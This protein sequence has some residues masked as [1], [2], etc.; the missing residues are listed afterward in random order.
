MRSL[1]TIETTAAR[2][3]YTTNG[4]TTAF[5]TTFQ[6]NEDAD[7]VVTDVDADGVETTKTLTTHYTV[8]GG[9]TPAATGTVTMLVAPATGSL[10]IQRI[11]SQL[12]DLDLI[13]QG[14]TPADGLEAQLDRTTMIVQENADVADRSITLNKATVAPAGELPAPALMAS[15]VLAFDADG[16]PEPS[17]LTITELEEQ[18][19]NAAA[20]A[21]ASAS[22]ASAASTSASAAAS[23]ASAASSSASA[24]AASAAI[25][26]SP[27]ANAL[28]FIRVNAGATAYEVQTAAEVLTDI[29]AQPLDADL[30]ALAAL[31][32]AANKLPY[33][34]GAQ[35]WAL[36]DYTAVA[37]TL[38]AQATQALMRSTGL[39]STTVGDAVFIATNGNAAALAIQASKSLVMAYH[40]GSSDVTGDGTAYT[41]T[42]GTE[43]YDVL[44]DFASNTFTARVTGKHRIT[45][46]ATA[47][48]AG[49]AHTAFNASIYVNG[50][51]V[52]RVG[53]CV[54]SI[55]G[56]AGQSM[57]IGGTDTPILTAGD[58]VTFVVAGAGSTKTMD[59]DGGAARVT[60]CQVEYVG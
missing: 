30:T 39:G 10:V 23:S 50:A 29:A 36:A 32:S 55:I 60:W 21:S 35:A 49:A 6:F 26:P 46:N 43:V 8:S 34:T 52:S 53:Y 25:I 3:V 14:A 58:T 45:F 5:P 59:L 38:D 4:V 12:Q 13:T 28:K 44:A 1:H 17:T 16:N 11:S 47:Y 42:F 15:K 20:S 51:Q 37:R 19:T 33:A 40:A 54:P 31:T 56:P 57:Q 7:L 2:K 9:G 18:P 27:T 24:A 22:S 41:V 48:G